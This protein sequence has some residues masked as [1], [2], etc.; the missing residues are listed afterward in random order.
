M[1]ARRP[2]GEVAAWS[3]VVA[4]EVH[5]YAG[6]VQ[7]LIPNW[8]NVAELTVEQIET[9]AQYTACHRRSC[10]E[11]PGHINTEVR[12]DL[13]CGRTRPADQDQHGSS[14]T[15]TKQPSLAERRAFRAALHEATVARYPIPHEL[16]D[17]VGCAVPAGIQRA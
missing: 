4:P 9:V 11:H 7:S 6:G 5:E 3:C 17:E 12:L 8:P 16:G 15:M 10:G 1:R 14:H 2:R 13:V